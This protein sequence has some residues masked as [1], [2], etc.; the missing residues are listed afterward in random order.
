MTDPIADMFI[1]IKNAQRV[2]A[3][4]VLMPYSKVKMEIAKLLQSRGLVADVFKR[5]KKN[6]KNIE[7]ILLYDSL[8]KGKI[9]EIKRVSKLSR[10]VY[11]GYKDIKPLRGGYGLYIISTSKGIM[12][13]ASTRRLKMGGEILGEVY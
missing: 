9:T 3:P 2:K 1:R 11:A 4:A 7:L 13:D 8:N 6:R 12:D 5:G 10:R